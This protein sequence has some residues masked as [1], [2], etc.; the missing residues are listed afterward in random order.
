[1]WIFIAILI[2]PVLLYIPPIQSIIKNIAF[3]KVEES[4]GMKIE[5]E[6]L[7]LKFPLDIDLG[8]ITIVEASGD[9]MVTASGAVVDVELL[10]LLRGMVS[11]SGATLDNGRYKMGTVDSSLYLV[12]RVERFTLSR[13]SIDLLQSVIDVGKARL[14][15]GDVEFVL[16][17]DTTVAPVDTSASTPWLIKAKDIALHNVR[18]RMKMLPTID[19]LSA[20]LKVAQ[21]KDGVVDIGRRDISASLVEVDSVTAAYFTP[22]AEFLANYVEPNIPV[23]SVSADGGLWRITSEKVRLVDASGVYAVAGAVPA[24]GLDMNYLSATDINIEVDSFY[25]RGVEIRVPLTRL[26]AHERCGISIDANGLFA[27]DSVGMEASRFDISTLFSSIRMDA[28]MGMGDMTSDSSV[29]LRLDADARI[30]IADLEMMMPVMK[31][32]LSQVPRYNDMHLRADVSGTAGSLRLYELSASLPGYVEMALSGRVTDMMNIDRIGGDIEIDGEITNVDFV[33]PTLLEAKL[34]EQVNIPPMT[35]HGNV[36]MRSGAVDGCLQAVTGSGL[37]ALDARWGGS[38]VDYEMVMA[39]DSFP[40]NSFMPLL[41]VGVVSADVKANGHGLNPLGDGATLSADMQIDEIVYNRHLYS[42]IRGWAKLADK[43]VNAGLISLNDNADFDVELSAVI[44]GDNYSFDV[45]GDIREIDLR[46]L[47]MSTTKAEGSLAFAGS[48]RVNPIRGDYDVTMAVDGLEWKMDGV[49][50][51]SER[52]DLSMLADSALTRVSLRERDLALD[53]AAVSSLDSLMAGFTNA[54]TELDRQVSERS[55]DVERFQRSL[56]RFDLVV[57]GGND[58]I[59]T[60]Y[61]RASDMDMRGLTVNARNDSLL[62]LD[63]RVLGFRSGSSRLDTIG[64][65]AMQR[66]RFLIYNATIDNKR[67]TMDAFAHVKANGYIAD[68]KMSVFVN[69]RNIS[70]SIGF[71]IGVVASLADSLMT[72]KFAPYTP[73]IGY[74]KWELN[75]DNFIEFN[76]ISK[77]MQADFSLT[78][79]DS[80]I[81]LFTQP[82]DSVPGRDEMRLQIEGLDIAEWLSVSPFAPPMKG[83]LSADLGFRQFK[84]VVGGKGTLA[85]DEFYFNRQRVGS[86]LFDVGVATNAKGKVMARADLM[87]D[88]IKTLQLSGMVNDTTG[89]SPYKLD[90]SMIKFPLR[91]LNPFM[92]SGMASF[93]GM[94]NGDIDITGNAEA[95]I[96]NGHLDFDSTSVKVDMIGTTFA[97]SETEIPIKD[98]LITFDGFMIKGVNNNPLAINGTVDM[99]NIVSPKFNLALTATDMQII[100]S[101]K[102]KKVDVYGKAFIDLTAMVIGDMSHMDVNAAVE[103]LGGTNVTYVMRNVTGAIPHQETGDMVRFVQFTDSVAMADA[104]ADTIAGSDMMAMSIDAIL[105][106]SEAAV[107]NVDLSADGNN[108]AQ[109]QGDGTLNYTMTSMGDSRFT[110]RYTIE[111]G[112]VRYTP[113][114]MSEKYFNFVAGSYIA[115]NGD[116]LNPILNVHAVDEMKV[117]V[118]QEGQ[119][120]RMVNFDI[121]AAVTGTLANM[122]VAFDLDA[123]DDISIAN[124]LQT[125]SAEQRANQAMNMLLYNT[126]TGPGSTASGN[127]IGN[128]LY[129]FLETQINTWAA[130]NIK[131]VDISFG[132]DQ[133]DSTKDGTK[134]TTTSYS[135]RV[136]KALFNDRF[137]IVVGGNYSTDADSDENFA[138]NL[139][140]DIS[141]EYMLNRSGSMY[142]KLFRHVG[143]ESILEGE[144]IQTGVGF[145]YKRKLRSL[146][147]LFRRS[148]E[149]KI[150]T[151]KNETKD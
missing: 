122:N 47:D 38:V 113:P 3:E 89:T 81:K 33:K 27:M 148:S 94:L 54:M 41:G 104:D 56:P 128:P 143:Y 35:L 75:S 96:L 42:N 131:G 44:D 112:F 73:I 118:T 45:S 5:I 103:L 146:R 126:Y 62:S 101:E 59:V 39:L 91:V 7:L 84:D 134:S 145:V 142:V 85:I 2:I 137:K 109:V 23:D 29:P 25:N 52:I 150:E 71:K 67:G 99:N 13:S 8:G 32:F 10:P 26:T 129:S 88:N 124:E 51:E 17:P 107:I 106:V 22:T 93:K 28:Y 16:Q 121:S 69:Q 64:L 147:E 31:P 11:V 90:F 135:Y 87:I 120:S 95:P 92:P 18:Y 149:P 136:S 108:R 55:I 30:G 151:E 57:N 1:M 80:Y 46:G 19:S 61:L 40:V 6:H 140:N 24:D 9:T 34:M 78:S 100:G 123:K 65:S 20:Q 37:L 66:S 63:G 14:D 43:N 97:F 132:I 130:N 68:D 98:N 119:N 76:Y 74:K 15:G 105:N 139:I 53:F 82:I 133:Y 58:N 4:T 115:F 83:V 21:L 114:L 36:A 48:G 141:F 127:I 50:L 86:F 79:A 111:K 116:M 102:G 49:N 70:D 12:A 72:L 60:Q 144:V 117:N 110:G 138:E 125:M 77:Q